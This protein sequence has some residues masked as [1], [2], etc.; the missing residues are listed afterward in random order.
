VEDVSDAVLQGGGV[1]EC[2]KVKGAWEGRGGGSQGSECSARQAR[3]WDSWRSE[4]DLP[5]VTVLCLGRCE[6]AVE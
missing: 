5:I 2:V 1:V 6:W 3:D 4:A